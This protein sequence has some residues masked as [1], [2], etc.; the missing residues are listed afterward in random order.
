MLRLLAAATIA[1]ILGSAAACAAPP[2]GADPDS[3]TGRW[4]KSLVRD[5]GMSCCSV[6]D[7]RPAGP[8]ELRATDSSSL[9]VRV[10]SH[11]VEVPEYKIVRRDD[12]PIGKSIICRAALEVFCVI[13]YAGL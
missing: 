7:C 4:F 1:L 6:S 9:E 5:D 13:P 3:P 2:E 8:D 12:N 11:W 10:E